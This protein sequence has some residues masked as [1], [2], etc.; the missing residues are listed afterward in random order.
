MPRCLGGDSGL[1]CVSDGLTALRSPWYPVS[2][3]TDSTNT[4]S[5]SHSQTAPIQNLSARLEQQ[6]NQEP[7]EVWEQWPD[8]TDVDFEYFRLY[9]DTAPSARCIAAVAEDQGRNPSGIY[10]LSRKWKWRSRVQAWDRHRDSLRLSAEESEIVAM[11]RRH[12]TL[13]RLMQNIGEN[14]VMEK[15]AEFEEGIPI[16]M[17]ARE[18]ATMIETG[19]RLEAAS[20]DVEA[21]GGGDLSALDAEELITYH[22]LRTK[23]LAGKNG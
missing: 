16:K 12:V 11:R 14:W 22:R 15:I 10:Q 17:S 7:V 19:V 18:A 4:P 8:E 21:A 13:A 20:V 3:V 9:R 1:R 2:T 6:L 5:E 23:I